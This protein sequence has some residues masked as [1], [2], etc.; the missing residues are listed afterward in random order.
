MVA[1]I[2]SDSESPNFDEASGHIVLTKVTLKMPR[3][4]CKQSVANATL[5]TTFNDCY[6]VLRSCDPRFSNC[7]SRLAEQ[8]RL[9]HPKIV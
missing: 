3:H 8:G 4:G 2:D 6:N 7:F 5:L 1:F 9:Q